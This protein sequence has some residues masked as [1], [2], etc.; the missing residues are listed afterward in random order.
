MAQADI[1]ELP[2]LKAPLDTIKAGVA[3][4]LP[5]S[6]TLDIAALLKSSTNTDKYMGALY[7][8]EPPR[9]EL[10]YSTKMISLPDGQNKDLGYFVF[11][12][13]SIP[14]P[15][16]KW[17]VD[18]YIATMRAL[19]IYIKD[20]QS[21]T[22]FEDSALI[23]LHPTFPS[24]FSVLRHTAMGNKDQWTARTYVVGGGMIVKTVGAVAN[25]LP[26]AQKY[27]V[28]FYE[29]FSTAKTAEGIKKS[30]NHFE[31]VVTE[32]HQTNQKGEG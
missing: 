17:R 8:H 26:L 10:Q 24:E 3:E 31:G 9:V 14:N 29:Q 16:Y 1:K 6:Q 2:Y 30:V 21:K 12:S 32:R 23:M 28:A 13:N 7:E 18:D 19:S 5:T 11:I 15:D 22:S 25:K 20:G 27:P 4:A